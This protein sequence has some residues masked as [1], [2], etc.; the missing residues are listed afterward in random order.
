MAS[1]HIDKERGVN[2]G[3]LGCER[4]GEDYGV[5]LYGTGG[6]KKKCGNCGT[7]NI[8]KRGERE[9]AKCHMVRLGPPVRLAESEKVYIGLCTK[10]EEAQ[11]AT[12][13]AVKDGGIYWKCS[14]CGAAGALK[15]DAELAKAVRAQSGISA[16]DPVGVEFS[17]EEMCPVCNAEDQNASV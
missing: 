16:P 2:P 11:K 4:C 6:Y 3:V 17:K 9:C 12:D 10:C 8:C 15:K 1:I 5:A 7:T 14:D 13:E